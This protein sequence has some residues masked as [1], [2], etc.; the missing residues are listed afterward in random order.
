ME[1]EMPLKKK[2]QETPMSQVGDPI[3]EG[4]Q[5]PNSLTVLL[6]LS[7]WSSGKTL[8]FHCRRRGFDPWLGT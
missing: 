1:M 6:G 7:W 2:K 4:K 5:F 8:C 3:K